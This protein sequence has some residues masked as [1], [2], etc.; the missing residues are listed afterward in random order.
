MEFRFVS[1]V[2]TCLVSPHLIIC[3]THVN[4]TYFNWN[5]GWKNMATMPGSYFDHG[6]KHGEKDF[7]GKVA[8]I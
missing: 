4:T 6:E 3:Y 1:F 8:R 2:Q 7:L 5:L